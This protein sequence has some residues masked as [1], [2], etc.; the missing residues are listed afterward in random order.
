MFIRSLLFFSAHILARMCG[1]VCVTNG[2]MNVSVCRLK[3]ANI[4]AKRAKAHESP[5]PKDNKFNIF[6]SRMCRLTSCQSRSIARIF[7]HIFI[8]FRMQ[9]RPRRCCNPPCYFWRARV[10]GDCH[11]SCIHTHTHTRTPLERENSCAIPS[12][13]HNGP[14]SRITMNVNLNENCKT[15]CGTGIAQRVDGKTINKFVF[16]A[17]AP[18]IL[19]VLMAINFKI[20]LSDT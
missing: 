2:P 7:T 4:D 13:K 17:L 5:A 18:N 3:T 8:K 12:R 14:D 6:L 19:I 16:A 9:W 11:R 15:D 1:D 20:S 10:R